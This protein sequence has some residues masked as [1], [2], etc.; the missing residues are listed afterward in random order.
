MT[1][2]EFVGFRGY[3]LFSSAAGLPLPPG[4][5]SGSILPSRVNGD[6]GPDALPSVDNDLFRP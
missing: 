2:Q 4:A 5:D 6:A 1:E 3:Y